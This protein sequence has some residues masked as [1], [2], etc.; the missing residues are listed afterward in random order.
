VVSG[1]AAGRWGQERNFGAVVGLLNHQ[2]RGLVQT[3]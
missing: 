2:E 1:G 3:S